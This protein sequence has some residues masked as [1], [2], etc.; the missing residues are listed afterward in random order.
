MALDLNADQKELGRTNANIVMNDLSRRG[1]MKSLAAGAG[2]AAVVSAASYFGYT[3]FGGKPVR[4]GLIGAGDEGGVLVGEHNP[5]FLQ[6]VAAAD[7]RPSNQKRIIDGD[8]KVPLRKGFKKVYGELEASKIKITDK[9]EEIL[10][11]PSIEAVVIALP[12]HLHAPVAI[13][14]MEAGKHVLCEK[15]MA[16]NIRQCK[17]MIE[18]AKKTNRILSIGH[19]RHYSML[20]AHASEVI[21]SGILGD[22]KYI[23]ALWHRNNTWPFEYDPAKDPALAK[24]VEQPVYRDGW[25]NPIYQADYDLLNDPKKLKEFGYKSVE[26]LIRWRLYNATGGGLMA[27]LGSH[28]LDACSIF[29][30]KVHP[31]VVS[32]TGTKSFYGKGRNDRD[33]D[34]HVFVTYE[35]PGNNYY[36]KDDAGK[37]IVREG[38][39]LIKDKDDVVVVNYSS[40]STNQFEPYGECVTGSRG[41]MLVESEQNLMLFN[42]RNPAGK[43][44]APKTTVVS[45]TGAEKGKPALEASSTWGPAS[46]APAGAAAAG[47][48]GTTGGPVSRG[49]RE[50]MED[51]AFCIR[52]WGKDGYKA[53]LRLPRCHGSVAMADAIVA[54]TANLAMK[55][56]ARI[57]F[58]E[59]WF[60][61]GSSE[62]PDADMKGRFDDE[63]F[64]A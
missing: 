36:Q 18:V 19:Q 61:P 39:P 16:W 60:E 28:Q 7:I 22:I 53:G 43:G 50:E 40:I 38:K 21:K 17:K 64:K 41:T 5:E 33:S 11:D 15:L 9:Y 55:R 24:G 1:F 10:A 45:V 32:G 49:Y 56:R 42:E 52:N 30:G 34:D 31:L 20:Y 62:V 48:A 54:L 26:E 4:A 47:P 58:D 35:F 27:E 51:F 3:G 23:R 25:Y 12:L 8:P 14:A 46:A 13:K 6:F 63:I 2:G 59:R 44:G 57:E 29:L 37:T